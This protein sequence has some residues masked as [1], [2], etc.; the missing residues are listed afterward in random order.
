IVDGVLGTGITGS[1]RQP[2]CDLFAKVNL[3]TAPVL[4]L[5]LPSGLC[6]NTGRNLGAVISANATI[7]FIAAKQ[8]LFTGHAAEYVGELV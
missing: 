6:A 2:L 4:S 8:G 5:D 3:A 1:L 7:T